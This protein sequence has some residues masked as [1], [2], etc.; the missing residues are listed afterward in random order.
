MPFDALG[1]TRAT[2]MDSKSR[3]VE[4]GK[5]FLPSSKITETERFFLRPFSMHTIFSQ[6]KV[7][8]Y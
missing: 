8:V 1:R 6:E 3:L 5:F 7:Y 4:S 2:M